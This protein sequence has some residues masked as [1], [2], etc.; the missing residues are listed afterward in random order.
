MRRHLLHTALT[1]ALIA[2]LPGTGLAR[3]TDPPAGRASVGPAPSALWAPPPAPHSLSA[4]V[5]A[6]RPDPTVTGLL[7][8]AGIGFVA[9]WAFYDYMCEAVDNNCYGSRVPALVLTSGFF[10]SLGAL[11][12]STM[13]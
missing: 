3:E 8:G 13:D 1:V 4:S 2:S 9:G 6:E 5:R 10:A 11:I 12:G 7:V